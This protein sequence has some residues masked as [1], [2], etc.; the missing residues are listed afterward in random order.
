MP[1]DPFGYQRPSVAKKAPR[2][3]ANASADAGADARGVNSQP[4]DGVPEPET[5]GQPAQTGGEDPSC[6]RWFSCTDT[7]ARQVSRQSKLTKVNMA[8]QTTEIDPTY[9]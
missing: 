2:A 5:A 6:L 8:H 1:L 7:Y 9:H 4:G 3:S